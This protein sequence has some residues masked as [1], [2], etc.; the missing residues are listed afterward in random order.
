MAGACRGRRCGR[1]AIVRRSERWYGGCWGFRHVLRG[2]CRWQGPVLQH[3]YCRYET[4]SGTGSV[5]RAGKPDAVREFVMCLYVW[6]R[7]FC[8]LYS[9]V[10]EMRL[11]G[12]D[13]ELRESTASDFEECHRLVAQHV[14]RNIGLDSEAAEAAV[15]SGERIVRL[16]RKVLHGTAWHRCGTSS[17]RLARSQPDSHLLCLRVLILARR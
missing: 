8:A 6:P 9:H 7:V 3:R 10:L 17:P 12:I 13:V 5:S 16:P 15:E 2:R 1:P 11:C 4:V 14:R